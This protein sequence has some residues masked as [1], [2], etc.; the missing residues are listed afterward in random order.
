[1]RSIDEVF[2]KIQKK[3]LMR[4]AQIKKAYNDAFNL[5]LSHVNGE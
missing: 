4:K 1:M 5:E 2:E 3:L